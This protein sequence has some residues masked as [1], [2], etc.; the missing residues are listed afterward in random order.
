ME[1]FGVEELLGQDTKA[2]AKVEDSIEITGFAFA[3]DDVG[4]SRVRET[5]F[6]S[7]FVSGPVAFV[8]KLDDA[9]RDSRDRIHKNIYSFVK[10]L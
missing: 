5:A 4:N 1:E 10:D 3:E 9:G 7:E 2:P 6:E 8:E